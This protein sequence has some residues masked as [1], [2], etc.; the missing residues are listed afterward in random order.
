MVVGA[1]VAGLVAAV[2]LREAGFDVAVLE[3]RDR[4][5]GRTVNREIPGS[6]GQV[7]EM[8]GQWIGPTQ[9]RAHALVGELGLR[10]YPTYDQGRHTVEWHRRLIRPT[11]RIQL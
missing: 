1:G 10:L 3:A 9:A 6:G 2:C 8:G 7:I 4:V 11:R 5:G